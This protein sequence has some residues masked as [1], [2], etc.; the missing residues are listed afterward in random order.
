MAAGRDSAPPPRT[1][2]R[3]P[4]L[5]RP[6][7]R[8]VAPAYQPPGK[9][10]GGGPATPLNTKRMIWTGAFAAVTFVGAVYGAG[11][12]TQQE[13][14]AEKKQIQEAPIEDRIRGLEDRRATLV[15]QKIPLEWKLD[16]LRAR[17]RAKEMKD[18]EENQ[19]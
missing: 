19:P 15:A 3:I 7:K 11:L 12:K 17:M 5:P 16:A 8:G 9:P 14:Q 6:I 18:A 13:Y 1:P 2:S 10:A 4:H